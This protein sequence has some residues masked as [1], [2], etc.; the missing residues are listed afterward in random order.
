[1]SP[2]Q[3]RH[4]NPVTLTTSPDGTSLVDTPAILPEAIEA[5]DGTR[6]DAVDDDLDHAQA[7]ELTGER[8]PLFFLSARSLAL[9]AALEHDI[10]E[11]ERAKRPQAKPSAP[12][13]PRRSHAEVVAELVQKSS[14]WVK[15]R[16]PWLVPHSRTRWT[17]PRFFSGEAEAERVNEH[18]HQLWGRREERRLTKLRAR[19]AAAKERR[20][21]RQE[22]SR[23]RSEEAA[24]RF[25][26]ALDAFYDPHSPAE[27]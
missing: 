8:K 21:R 2:Y 12:R 11:R 19:M 16:R 6:V 27:E 22:E 13:K 7:D 24:E 1:M 20:A 15:K 4:I 9:R 3:R 17:T 26:A 25:F 18:L 14:E 5:F 10:H 23:K